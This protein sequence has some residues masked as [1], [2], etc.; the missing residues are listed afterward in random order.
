MY[1]FMC[2]QSFESTVNSVLQKPKPK[3]APTP[4]ADTNSA[5][6]DTSGGDAKQSDQP[7]N[8]ENMDVE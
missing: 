6:T 7:P 3:P 2:C 8:Q 1:L 4:A 5:P